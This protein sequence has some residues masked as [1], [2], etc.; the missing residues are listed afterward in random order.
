[1][2]AR[3]GFRLTSYLGE[4]R[5]AYIGGFVLRG[6]KKEGR[7]SKKKGGKE[8]VCGAMEASKSKS[9]KYDKEDWIHAEAGKRGEGKKENFA[10]QEI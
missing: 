4:L 6:E 8:G 3:G 2:V 7:N 9:D 1:M 5:R 10:L